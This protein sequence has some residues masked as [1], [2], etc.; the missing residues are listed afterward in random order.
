MT[1]ILFNRELRRFSLSLWMHET[2][3]PSFKLLQIFN[4]EYNLILTICNLN[5]IVEFIW[6]ISLWIRI[7]D[8]CIPE[9][10]NRSDTGIPFVLLIAKHLV[11]NLG[12][13][14]DPSTPPVDNHISFY[15]VGLLQTATPRPIPALFFHINY[16]C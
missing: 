11:V 15:L 7:S 16:I 10:Y 6:W 2:S 9:I 8:S 3:S 5:K 1:Q 14:L 4:C 13:S 12:I